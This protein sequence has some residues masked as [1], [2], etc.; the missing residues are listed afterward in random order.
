MKR[1]LCGNKMWAAHRA[2][3]D[4]SSIFSNIMWPVTVKLPVWR[5]WSE[6]SLKISMRNISKLVY[7]LCN[8]IA[9]INALNMHVRQQLI[10]T[11][12]LQLTYCIWTKQ[13][14][15]A[16]S[17]KVL[18]IGG[19]RFSGLYLWKELYDRVSSIISC[20]QFISW[21]HHHLCCV[22]T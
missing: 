14:S 18:I 22:I 12:L 2:S 17:K 6:L 15:T 7:A 21:R 8:L 19:T 11:D 5:H 13:M 4:Y 20:H 10:V 16:T 9:L 1:I 3:S